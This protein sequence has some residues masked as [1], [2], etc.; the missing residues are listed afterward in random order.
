M[1]LLHDYFEPHTFCHIMQVQEL[2][3]GATQLASSDACAI[4]MY[5]VGSHILCIQGALL[6]AY[7]CSCLH[8]NQ[9]P[10]Q[11]ALSCHLVAPESLSL[12]LA[13]WLLNMHVPHS[14]YC[15]APGVQPGHH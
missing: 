15:R 3:P 9:V 12:P 11:L 13:S 14:S 1:G 8:S 5:S 7:R 10:P 6:D 2:P 4:A